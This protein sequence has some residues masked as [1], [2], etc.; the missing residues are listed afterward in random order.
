MIVTQKFISRRS[1]LRGLGVSVALP[2][3]DA[4]VPAMA[5]TRA[6][7]A[8]PALRMGFVYVPNGIIDLKGEWTPKGE[9]SDFAFSEIGKGSSRIAST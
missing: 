8:K 3:M 4:M 5:A 7:A 1:V 6:G 2:M 9:G